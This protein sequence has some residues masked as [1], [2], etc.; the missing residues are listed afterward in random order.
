MELVNFDCLWKCFPD[1]SLKAIGPPICSVLGQQCDWPTYMLSPRSTMRLELQTWQ[2]I[3]SHEDIF[4][5]PKRFLKCE[6]IISFFAIIRLCEFSIRPKDVLWYP[7]SSTF[8]S[9]WRKNDFVGFSDLLDCKMG[10]YFFCDS[11]RL[12]LCSKHNKTVIVFVPKY[13]PICTKLST[14]VICLESR[15]T[16]FAI[17]SKILFIRIELKLFFLHV[18]GP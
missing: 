4:L 8:F 12:W 17:V 6:K 2:S 14:F 1:F 10:I 15:R 3:T 9:D 5:T 11:V 13:V 7:S 16:Y 18:L